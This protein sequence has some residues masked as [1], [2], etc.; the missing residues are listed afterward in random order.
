MQAQE[1][2][3]VLVEVGSHLVLEEALTHTQLEF[4]H[5]KELVVVAEQALT[6]K[7]MEEEEEDLVELE[8]MQLV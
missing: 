6:V 7:V 4:Q 3:R 1:V 2:M 8:K 5:H